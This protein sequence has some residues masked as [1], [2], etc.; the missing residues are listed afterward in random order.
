MAHFRKRGKTWY[1]YYYIAD[2]ETGEP[3][4]K[5]KG[6]FRTR[7]DAVAWNTRREADRLRG[8]TGA[9]DDLTVSAYMRMYLDSRPAGKPRPSSMARYWER[10]RLYIDPYIGAVPLA[11]LDTYTIR[12]WHNQLLTRQNARGKGVGIAPITIRHTHYLLSSALNEAIDN[13]MLL[14]NP[15]RLVT[16][17]AVPK[18]KRTRLDAGQIRT[19]LAVADQH[20]LGLLYRMAL[21]TLLRPG[22]LLALRWEDIDWQRSMILVRRT[23][24]RD[25]DGR[26]IIGSEPKTAAGERGIVIHEGLLRRLRQHRTEQNKHRLQ[27]AE[28]WHDLDLVFC[29]DN[30]MMLGGTRV[31]TTLDRLCA[32]AEVPRVTPHE[33]RHS[34][35]SL[36]VDLNIHLKAISERLGHATIAQTADIYLGVS[37]GLQRQIAGQLAEAIDAS[38]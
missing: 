29:R 21:F 22:E 14:R 15:C 35:A 12:T 16:P 32:E 23:R 19:F 11:R 31:S 7:G 20:P 36:M 38:A 34:G 2:P 1:C 13:G 4:Q 26:Y 6:G 37:E 18:S 27:Y 17:P 30:G 3:K 28:L 5:S 25:E 10:V 24:T 8:F 9:P 33:L